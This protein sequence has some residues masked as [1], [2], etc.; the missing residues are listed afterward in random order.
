M[1]TN[2]ESKECKTLNDEFQT[3][4]SLTYNA[5]VCDFNDFNLSSIDEM[6]YAIF[7]REVNSSDFHFVCLASHIEIATF[8]NVS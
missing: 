7:E 2:F 6:Q 4:F 5:T 3:S 8:L 1:V